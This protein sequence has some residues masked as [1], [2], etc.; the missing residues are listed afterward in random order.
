MTEC[1]AVI[2]T[3]TEAYLRRGLPEG[4]HVEA[5]KGELVGNDHIALSA[6]TRS[7][8]CAAT[9][10]MT[11]GLPRGRCDLTMAN[12]FS[13]PEHAACKGLVTIILYNM[14]T[15]LADR[16]GYT[17]LD[18]HATERGAY[19]W[20]PFFRLDPRESLQHNLIDPALEDLER[21]RHHLAAPV[22]TEAKALIEGADDNPYALRELIDL[23]QTLVYDPKM[24]G[25]NERLARLAS[26]DG[27]VPLPL[28]VLWKNAWSGEMTMTRGSRDRH[29][30]AAKAGQYIHHNRM[31]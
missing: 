18:V 2:D 12:R 3:D 19:Q 16:A 9:L 29:R 24:D 13:V 23:D 20:A 26:P 8:Y 15:W 17:T 31:L 27:A 14:V 30:L 5:S 25:D 21:V 6:M 1:A 28:Y 11:L 10:Y 7:G 22:F 4:M